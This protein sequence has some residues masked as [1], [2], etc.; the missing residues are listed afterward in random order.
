MKACIRSV[1][2]S[3]DVLQVR[4]VETPTPA[5]DEV[6]VQV[7]ASS[8]D[9]GVWH[10]MTGYPLVMRP[11]IGLRAPKVQVL[12]RAFAGVVTSVGSS[13]TRFSAGDQVFGT[14]NAG[15]WAEYTVAPERLL[16]PLPPEVT[17]EQGA[18]VGCSGTTALQALRS[19]DVRAGQRVMVIGAGGGVGS[20]AVQLAALRGAGVTAVCGASKRELVTSLGADEV[21][22]YTREEVDARGPRYDVIVDC[23]GNRPLSLLRKALKPGGAL[24]SVGGEDHP[25]RL[26]QGFQ[27]QMFRPIA[28]MFVKRRIRSVIAREGGEDLVELGRLMAAGELTPAIPRTYSLA[29]APECMRYLAEGHPAGKVLISM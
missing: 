13:V 14:T 18:S 15:S 17:F 9:R 7:R 24:V 1:Y 10:M 8:N 22:D 11:V 21:I 28:G 29:E 25:G 12:G 5:D 16:A 6:L 27:W 26:M 3:A 2:G 4:D 19:G 23:A 20:F